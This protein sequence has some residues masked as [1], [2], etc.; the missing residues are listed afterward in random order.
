[1]NEEEA[2]HQPKAQP[3]A[4]LPPCLPNRKSVQTGWKKPGYHH[5][6]GWVKTGWRVSFRAPKVSLCR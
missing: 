1:M 2:V 4:Q 3:K 6:Y 5:G